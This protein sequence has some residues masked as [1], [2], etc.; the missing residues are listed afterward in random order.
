MD[1]HEVGGLDI[2]VRP[3]DREL[4]SLVLTDRT[5]EHHPVVCVFA[6]SVDE[7][8]TI[9]HTLGRDQDPLGVQP[10]E[11]IAEPFT[12]LA[13]PVLDRHLEIVEEDLR[14]RVVDHG[15]NRMDSHPVPDG[16][17]EIH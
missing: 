1:A 8:S 14:R 10:V 3:R 15:A 4:N 9:T 12:L 7:P 6:G 2:D 17:L 11:Q 13:N 16:V 5:S